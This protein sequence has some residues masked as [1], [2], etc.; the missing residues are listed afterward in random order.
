MPDASSRI[1]PDTFIP[2]TY[3]D[4]NLAQDHFIICGLGSLGQQSIVNLDKFSYDPF[5]VHIAA[6]DRHPP[7]NWEVDDLP[8]LLV[9]PPILGD[10]RRDDVLRQAG[11]DHCRA[12]LIVTSD[13][14]T[15]VETAI[16][17]RRL[18]PNVHIVLRSSRHS[19]N[20]LLAKQLGRFVALDATELPAM[21]FALAGLGEGILSVFQVGPYRFRVIERLV[22]VG[23]A[24]YENIAI[25]RLH[26]RESRLLNL[27]PQQ[28][29]HQPI[30]WATTASSV[31]HRWQPHVRVQTGDQIAYVEV[32]YHRT[33]TIALRKRPKKLARKLGGWLAD[34][35][36]GD[37]RRRFSS[38]WRQDA[39]QSLRRVI[40]IALSTGLTLWVIGTL[41]LKWSVS[42]LSW[43]KAI[44]L[45]AILLLG[46]YGDVF[47]GFGASRVPSWVLLVCLMISVTS[48]LVVL[49]VFGL[50]AD[51]L[52][53]S[54]F[55]FLQ[56]RP[57]LPK[58][59]HV[60]IVGL[61]RVGQRVIRILKDLKQPLV[62]ITHQ[63]NYPDLMTQ[64]P[65][66]LGDMLQ[67]LPSANLATAKSVIAVTDD[68]II[69]LEIALI[70]SEAAAAEGKSI[71]PVVRTLD[72][73]FSNNLVALMPQARAFSV[74]ALSAEAFA[75]AAFGENILSLFRLNEQTILVAEYHIESGDTLSD[76][77]LAE[78]TYG[79]GVVPVLLQTRALAG[80][81]EDI[82][83]PSDDLRLHGGDCLYVLSSINGLRR[84][85][86]GEM[87]PPRRWRL[88]AKAPL[89]KEVLLEAGNALAKM[90]GLNL[91]QC[92]A[93]MNNLP[94]TMELLLYDYQAYRLVQKL[95][96]R[97]PIQLSPL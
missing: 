26:R 83:M 86:R 58:K 13:E 70:A 94:S 42:T 2:G 32:E 14:S 16:A 35:F 52:L 28:Q 59:D 62:G 4:P 31:F 85:E 74:Y 6:I 37:W 8:S 29:P 96:R 46:G 51:Q 11:I 80:D 79:Y 7:D 56:R 97:L 65:L 84:I 17:A 89:N 33:E 76:R 91:S 38:F 67:E 60:I 61:G 50:L 15:N 23:E 92:R 48:L 30:G 44:S 69:N 88:E 77:L 54:R 95:N 82:L 81:W 55:D 22:E 72:Q 41:L 87:T 66:L 3:V 45:G 34:F 12:I 63:L 36:D 20:T 68:P 27:K 47:G 39:Q 93:F 49:G 57:R 40:V 21:T 64:V 53:S 73:T 10:C 43:P 90:S 19:L 5:E 24:Q 75:G 78:V 25:H 18:N 71:S 1:S 9:E